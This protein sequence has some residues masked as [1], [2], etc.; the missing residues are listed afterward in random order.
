MAQARLITDK[1]TA[2]MMRSLTVL[3][4]MLM[5]LMGIGLFLKALPILKEHSILEMLTSEE[6]KP[7]KAQFGFYPYIM[8]TVWVTLIAIII[9]F[10]LCLLTSVYLFEYAP[11]RVKQIISPLIDLLAGIPPV[12]YGV[13]GVITIV[14]L[15]SEKI[16]PHYVEYSSGYS[17]LAGGIVLSVMIFPLVISLL[18]EVFNSISTDL[19]DASLSLGATKWQTTKLVLLRK[20]LPGIIASLILAV[21]RALGETIAV[22]MV[23]GNIAMVPH[24]IFDSGYPLPA[25]IANNYGEMLS[26][27]MYDSALMLA[28]FILFIIIVV[29]N[30]LSRFVLTGV[31]KYF[32]I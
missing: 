26:I 21:S 8:G 11:L 27:P 15:I 3:S 14:P 25:L 19:R 13:W 5:F 6:W 7:F 9:S 2:R 31:E 10:P 18:G 16:A 4:V 1:V 32:K 30:V 20:A 24:S 29:F 23:C 28:A 17:V 22:L 12:V